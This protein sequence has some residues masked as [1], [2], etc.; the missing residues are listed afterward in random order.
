LS[1]V[2]GP[3]GP[4]FNRGAN[5]MRIH[6]SRLLGLSISVV[7]LLTSSRC[8]FK[9]PVSPSWDVK[10][11]VPLVERKYT[12]V[13]LIEDDKD[14]ILE[15]SEVVYTFM[16]DIEPFR[17]GDNLR[18]GGA[19]VNKTVSFGTASD[20]VALPDTIVV[21]TAQIKKGNIRVEITNSHGYPIQAA[22]LMRELTLNGDP[23]R[24]NF[25]VQSNSHFVSPNLILD[26]YRFDTTPV[27]GRNYVYYDATLSGGP[28]SD[29]V[30][31]RLTV[32]DIVYS[33]L[34]GR[35]KAVDVSFND[36]NADI[37]IPDA[38]KGFQIGSATADL[39]ILNGIQFPASLGMTVKG[40]NTDGESAVLSVPTV[41]IPKAPGSGQKSSTTVNIQSM[42]RIVNLFPS[43]IDFSG[44]ARLGDGSTQSQIT[45]WDEL[46]GKILFKAPMIFSLPDT[47]IDADVDTLD[48]DKDA[49]DQF[50]NINYASLVTQVG[51]HLPIG[52]SISVYFSNTVGDKNIYGNYALKRDLTVKPA[53]VS[54]NP[55]VVTA[56]ADT[57]SDFK[58]EK[59][60][61]KVFQ[62]PVVYQGIR[63]KFP[64]TAKKMV[65][66][67]P[68]DYIRVRT[69]VEAS[70]RTD[71]E[72]DDDSKGGGS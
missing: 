25:N 36:I 31:V 65:R 13:D 29:F 48:I 68:T 11:V 7:C 20:F 21:N 43:R 39:T 54:G 71:F 70:V 37:D 64:G 9:K 5:P 34:T 12:M 50:D 67:R 41:S 32:S 16:E 63:I 53:P 47:V 55:G 49:R 61:W 60:D 18:S 15:N 38:I 57:S 1:I 45:E 6:P 27:N 69:R 22:F 44:S 23:F 35:L 42:E 19:V 58:M 10:F 2:K 17:V 59:N 72:K 51:N 26:G 24:V 8:T 3:V 33:S 4:K 56:E 66:I 52:F 28:A 46:S 40:T 14:F 62:N 30:A